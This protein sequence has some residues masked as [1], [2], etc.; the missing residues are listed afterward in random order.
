M[1]SNTNKPQTVFPDLPRNEPLV[2]SSGN[3][4]MYWQL[5]FQNLVL[6]LQTNFKNEGFAIPPQSA[7]NI[8]L[9]TGDQS[10]GNIVYDSTNDVFKGNMAGIWKT[11]LT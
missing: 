1:L 11:F 9:L 7:S 8:A 4:T 2:D 3:M 5:F 6:A 10:I